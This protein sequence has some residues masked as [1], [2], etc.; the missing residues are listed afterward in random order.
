MGNDVEVVGVISVK[1]LT[2][3]EVSRGVHP[4]ELKEVFRGSRGECELWAKEKGLSWESGK[5]ERTGFWYD[6]NDLVA[7]LPVLADL[8][9]GTL[10]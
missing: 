9:V 8:F 5:G 6:G 2:L 7:Y 4:S 10:G 1:E 3:D